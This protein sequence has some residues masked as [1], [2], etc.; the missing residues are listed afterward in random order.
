MRHTL[1]SLVALAAA[2]LLALFPA[3]AQ[4]Q[5]REHDHA[6]CGTV[7]FAEMQQ[8]PE[9]L[10]K[11]D[12]ELLSALS[13]ARPQTQQL[14]YS[15]NRNFALHYDITGPDAVPT[16]DRDGNGTPDYIDSAALWLEY[17]RR[18]EVDEYGYLAPPPDNGGP[19]PEIDV[20][21]QNLSPNGLY[22]F[23]APENI[24]S[25]TATGYLVLDND[26][27]ESLY[28]SNGMAGVRVTSAHE[29]HH[30]IQFGS[31]RYDLT[32][33]TVYEATSVWFERQLHPLI[34]DYEPYL[35]A[36]FFAPQNYGMSTHKVSD[37]VT[38]YA[39]EIYMDY[40]ATK[41]DRDVVRS[42]WERFRD[43]P[44]CWRA[45]DRALVDRGLNLRTSVEEL[46]TWCYFSGARAVDDTSYFRG[47]DTMPPL[48]VARFVQWD[49]DVDEV[50]IEGT[51][52]P[53][54]F[55]LYQVGLPN[56]T[57]QLRDT[58]TFVVTNSRT[59]LPIGG[60]NIE[61]E[62]FTIRLSRNRRDGD[63]PV[64][65]PEDSIAYTVTTFGK[66]FTVAV[67]LGRFGSVSAVPRI[68]P[69]PFLNDGVNRLLFDLGE[70]TEPS[71]IRSITLNLY[72]VGLTPIVHI[73]R[74]SL[75]V[76]RQ[77]MGVAWDGRDSRGDIVPSGVYIYEMAVNGEAPRL[78]KV[79]VIRR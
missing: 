79:M 25:N 61:K 13:S 35:R 5:P 75:D 31:Y 65:G 7:L 44:N 8:H 18:V 68:S 54:G 46:S 73:E 16:I 17:A 27:T 50:V 64:R 43:E 47:A 74:T 57:G 28:E 48:R 42:I 11:R 78:G 69:Q 4:A 45:V 23:A 66:T 9:R 58:V 77:M 49:P 39:H 38:G 71:A 56:A 62:P 52:F 53:L 21:F 20:Y 1:T 19:G 3:P 40:L 70:A 60:N 76:D 10:D 32:Q 26:Y 14:I 36:L 63:R 59:D 12:R 2:L 15:A 37:G 30:L 67:Y 55:G 33:A 6:R 51:L 24:T 72:S 41:L 29:L 22:G 34:P